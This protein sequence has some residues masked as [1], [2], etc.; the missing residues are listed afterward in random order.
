MRAVALTPQTVAWLRALWQREASIDGLPL[1]E[2]DET[3]LAYALAVRD[4]GGA[5]AVLDAQRDRITNPDRHARFEFVRGAAAT[6]AAER[7][8]W[9]RAL[10]DPGVRRRENWVGEGLA[11][12]NH[13]LRAEPSAD[14]VRKALDM[15]LEVHRTGDLFFDDSWLSASLSGHASA[16]V[17]ATVRQ[18]IDG[19]PPDYPP[20]VRALVIQRSDMLM[21][22]SQLQGR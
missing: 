13:P 6:D 7:E 2:A 3:A 4:I 21:R 14:L 20:R 12:L 10:E 5:Q 8:R 19:L 17:A 1:V 9:F 11:L 16:R 15:L 18:F 22:A